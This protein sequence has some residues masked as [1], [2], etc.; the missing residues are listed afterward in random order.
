[1]KKGKILVTGGLGYIGSHTVVELQQAGYQVV[2]VDNLSNSVPDVKEW[3]EAITGKTVSFYNKDVNDFDGLSHIFRKNKSIQAVVHFAAYKAVGESVE[4]PLDYY[5]NNVGGMMTLLDVMEEFNCHHMVFS[6]SCT[7]YGQ[8][9]ILPVT[10]NTPISKAWSP[11]GS[12]K[13]M[14]EQILEDVTKA[15]PLRAISLRYF[16]P[17]GAHDSAL[18]GEL[19]KGIPNNLV[20]FIT[21]S[22]A[23]KRGPI[24]V[25]G[26]DYPTEDG[27]CIRDY[28]HV[29]DL[30]KAHVKALDYL[31]EQQIDYDVFNIGTGQ[32]YSVLQIIEAFR[33]STHE[34]LEVIMGPRRAGDVTAVWADTTKSANT[35]DWKPEYG[36]DDMMRTAWNWQKQ[37]QTLFD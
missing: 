30:A 13:I 15:N 5:Y 33:N 21:Q 7:V 2:V 10:E 18:I 34:P 32:G 9:E 27:T 28:I 3:I 1:M 8:P 36:L 26:N 31:F 24:T 35:L 29:S 4:K 23:G 11:Y 17:V 22:A 16:N 12:T 25:F 37:L 14:C 20:P 6:S 19:P